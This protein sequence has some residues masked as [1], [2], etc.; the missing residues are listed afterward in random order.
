MAWLILVIGGLFEVVWSYAMKLSEGFTHLSYTLVCIVAMIISVW[1]LAIAMKTLPLGTSYLAWTGIGAVGAFIV[2][3]V[4]L[5]EPA[6]AQ[7][8]GAALLI[9][10]GI[11][12]IGTAGD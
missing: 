1:F 12:L 7:R 3:V 2:G 4:A 10:A 8:I 11:V 6:T 5:G 9:L